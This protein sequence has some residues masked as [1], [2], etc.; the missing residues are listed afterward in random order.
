MKIWQS[1]GVQPPMPHGRLPQV[2]TDH[3]HAVADRPLPRE[4]LRLLTLQ[5]E[6]DISV[7]YG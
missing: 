2:P 1:S 7:L 6:V 4:D 3:V 5:A